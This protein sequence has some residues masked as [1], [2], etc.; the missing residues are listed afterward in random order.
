M[1]GD[2]K[3]GTLF[4]IVGL[5]LDV[6]DGYLARLFNAQSELG[7]Q[8][9]SLSDMVTFGV[10]PAYLYYLQAPSDKWYYFVG[11]LF[12]I[13]CGALRLG[14]FNTL[15]SSKYF[16]GLPI[17]SNAIFFLGLFFALDGNNPFVT[18]LLDHKVPY[19]LIPIVLGFLMI[20]RMTMFSFKSINRHKSTY[21][22]FILLTI[23]TGLFAVYNW[24]LAVSGAI[25]FY[26]LIS[27]VTSPHPKHILDKS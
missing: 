13:C 12:V 20:S 25:V 22:P 6:F 18:N 26:I 11:P 27:L 5:I 21:I 19:T 2:M 15:P 9:D 7:K 8:L 17:P 16:I 3:L 14:K 4:I 1:I 23:C 24:R 10:A